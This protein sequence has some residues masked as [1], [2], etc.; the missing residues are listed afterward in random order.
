MTIEEGKTKLANLRQ[1]LKTTE[2]TFYKIQGGIEILEEQLMKQLQ[3]EQS[4][5]GDSV[6]KAIEKEGE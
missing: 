6:N 1:S 2:Q 4:K 3:E 5:E